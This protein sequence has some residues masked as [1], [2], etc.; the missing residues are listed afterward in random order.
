MKIISIVLKIFTTLI[1]FMLTTI[2]FMF[3]TAM[4]LPR[5]NGAN[6]YNHGCFDGVTNLMMEVGIDKI[7]NQEKLARAHCDKSV[8]KL[9]EKGYLF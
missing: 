1:V 3:T 7:K 6:Y 8:K 2:V 5:L 9:E 4:Y